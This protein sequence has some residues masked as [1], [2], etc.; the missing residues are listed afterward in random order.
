MVRFRLERGLCF[1]R[2]EGQKHSASIC[3]GRGCRCLPFTPTRME[4]RKRRRGSHHFIRDLGFRIRCTAGSECFFRSIYRRKRGS[5]ASFVGIDSPLLCKACCIAS[6]GK[7]VGR[8]ES[9]KNDGAGLNL[10]RAEGLLLIEVEDGIPPHTKDNEYTPS[11]HTKDGNPPPKMD[12][13]PPKMGTPHPRWEA[14][15]PPRRRPRTGVVSTV[16]KG[17][18]LRLHDVLSYV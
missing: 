4:R 13:P 16:R 14:L 15:P 10:R 8:R 3:L 12:P 5:W 6:L 11:P 9:E 7:R 18:K 1:V 2:V 17:W